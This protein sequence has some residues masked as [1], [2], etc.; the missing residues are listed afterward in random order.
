MNSA[1]IIE[2]INESSFHESLGKRL[3]QVKSND[4]ELA[5]VA[6]MALCSLGRVHQLL[7]GSHYYDYQKQEW[8]DEDQA[9]LDLAGVIKDGLESSETLLECFLKRGHAYGKARSK[10]DS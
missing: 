6:H 9:M 5:E 10:V 1:R 3:D 4:S 7:S 8:I 2:A